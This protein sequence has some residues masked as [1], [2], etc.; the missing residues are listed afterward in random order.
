VSGRVVSLT[1]TGRL[2]GEAA[3]VFLAQADLAASTRRSHQQTLALAEP[4]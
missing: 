4:G 2:L 3:V 1:A